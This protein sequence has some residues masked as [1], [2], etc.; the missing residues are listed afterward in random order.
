MNLEGINLSV[1][2]LIPITT[3][4]LSIDLLSHFP[5]LSFVMYLFINIYVIKLFHKFS[6]AFVS[7]T[8]ISTQFFNVPLYYYFKRK[9]SRLG[10]NL[11][12]G[13]QLFSRRANHYTCNCYSRGFNLQLASQMRLFEGLFVALDKC[14][15]VP[16]SFLCYYIFF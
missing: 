15:R 14:T 10:W 12:Q 2:I 4:Y 9:S 1:C 16:F 7:V 5:Q 6:Y 13:V 8:S 3:S 11:N